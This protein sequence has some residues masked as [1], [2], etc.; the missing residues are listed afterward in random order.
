[1]VASPH[2]RWCGGVVA[3]GK[4]GAVSR[5]PRQHGAVV[6]APALQNGGGAQ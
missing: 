6:G 5:G 3:V 2:T 1:M 4:C